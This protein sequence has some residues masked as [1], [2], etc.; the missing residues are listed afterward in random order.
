MEETDEAMKVWHS[1][2]IM[3]IPNMFSHILHIYFTYTPHVWDLWSI[4]STCMGSLV[5]V[6]RCFISGMSS[7]L[8]MSSLL[9]LSLKKPSQRA[10]GA[11]WL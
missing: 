4:H 11:L 6:A 8:V 5:K 1:V 9:L 10:Q 3:Y 2:V 7:S